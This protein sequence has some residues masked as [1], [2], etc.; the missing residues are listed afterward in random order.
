MG[1]IQLELLVG[2]IINFQKQKTILQNFV[3]TVVC[4]T[5]D[6]REGILMIFLFNINQLPLSPSL[7]TGLKQPLA[8]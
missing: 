3:V 7:P 1:L 2:G 5:E 4:S 6:G 8:L